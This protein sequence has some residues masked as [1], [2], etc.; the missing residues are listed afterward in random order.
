MNPYAPSLTFPSGRTRNRR[1][2]EKYLTLID[3]IALLHQHQRP[4]VRHEVGGRMLE[5]VPATLDDIALANELA[6]EVLGRSLD[7]LPPQTRALL[8]H[9]RS[10]VKAKSEARRA[11]FGGTPGTGPGRPPFSAAS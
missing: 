2:H 6:P 1:D 7:E 5:Y 9:I 4:W 10:L 3:S 11:A 8:G